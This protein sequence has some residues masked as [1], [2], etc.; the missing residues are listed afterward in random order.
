MSNM[1]VV[2]KVVFPNVIFMLLHK[3]SLVMLNWVSYGLEALFNTPIPCTNSV[4][5]GKSF[6]AHEC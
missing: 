4:V 2:A 6:R 5:L 3:L 1:L